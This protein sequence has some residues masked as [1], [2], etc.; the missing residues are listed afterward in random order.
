M[1]KKV[2]K[3]GRKF[4]KT[5]WILSG[6]F[7]NTSMPNP[8]KSLWYIIMNKSWLAPVILIGLKSHLL[9]LSKK[10]HFNY[11][12]WNHIENQ[13]KGDKKSKG[14][15]EPYHKPKNAFINRKKI[16]R[17]L[18]IRLDSPATWKR[19]FLETCIK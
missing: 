1:E 13:K 14:N 9:Q 15:Q 4:W 8:V 3:L 6:M 10:L 7:K 19:R 5:Y 2:Q 12:N 11:N 17:E 18:I 16:Y